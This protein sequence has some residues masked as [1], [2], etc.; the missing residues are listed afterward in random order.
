MSSPHDQFHCDPDDLAL[1]ALG[2][3]THID[4]DHLHRCEQCQ[5][6]AASL[7]RVVRT[8]RSIEA[9]DQPALPDPDLWRAVHAEITSEASATSTGAVLA[10]NDDSSPMSQH[11]VVPLRARRAP[12]VALAAAVGLVF[13]GIITTTWWNT[14]TSSPSIIAQAD[15]I[16]LDGF[17]TS[18]LAQV[19]MLDGVEVLE[20]GVTGLPETDGYFEVWL[21]TPD[22]DG[23]ISLGSLG[24][25]SS[26]KLPL[27]PGVSLDRFSVVDISEEKFD[28]DPTHSAISVTRGQLAT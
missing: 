17:N 9:D 23:M 2:E 24:A 7:R 27:P 10:T 11:N 18:G 16:G 28:G 26:T 3:T 12:W 22:V 14:Q 25:G 21:L 6:E 15:L 20:V 13:G 4:A 1:F 19:Q 8:A 5:A